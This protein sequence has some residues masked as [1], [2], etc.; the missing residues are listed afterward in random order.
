MTEARKLIAREEFDIKN[1]GHGFKIKFKDNGWGD[2]NGAVDTCQDK[3]AVRKHVKAG[4]VVEINS[5]IYKVKGVETFAACRIWT[6][7]VIVEPI[8]DIAEIKKRKVS[9]YMEV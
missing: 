7:G 9:I 6:A 2:E 5:T 8:Q 1:M 3:D 4:D